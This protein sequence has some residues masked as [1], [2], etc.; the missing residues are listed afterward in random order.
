MW[1]IIHEQ[2][3]H[4]DEK[5]HADE[6][7][8]LELLIDD[9][10]EKQLSNTRLNPVELLRNLLEANGIGQSELAKELNV[11]RQLISDILSYRRNISK[12]LVLKLSERFA[13]S[14]QAFSRRYR[15]KRKE[16]S[17]L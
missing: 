14:Q 12:E 7:E 17:P 16:T 1:L 15:L 9:F 6:I 10:E 11:S 3:M 8:L 5:A 4:A 2:L 13:M